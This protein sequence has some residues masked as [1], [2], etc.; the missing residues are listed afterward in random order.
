VTPSIVWRCLVVA[1]P[2][3]ALAGAAA[4]A[5]LLRRKPATLIGR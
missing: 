1:I 5:N 2:I 3:G 4:S